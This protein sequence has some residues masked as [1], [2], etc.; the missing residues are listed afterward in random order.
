MTESELVVLADKAFIACMG[1]TFV[2][3]SVMMLGFIVTAIVAVYR[4]ITNTEAPND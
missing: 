2:A 4:K 3:I 1:I